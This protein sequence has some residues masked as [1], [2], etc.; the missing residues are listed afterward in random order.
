MKNVAKI[1]FILLLIPLGSFAQKYVIVQTLLGKVP[2]SFQA[3]Y[4]IID[5]RNEDKQGKSVFLKTLANET[6]YDRHLKKIPNDNLRKKLGDLTGHETLALLEPALVLEIKFSGKRIKA[7]PKYLLLKDPDLTIISYGDAYKFLIELTDENLNKYLKL[8]VKAKGFTNVTMKEILNKMLF[9]FQV[10]GYIEKDSVTITNYP[11]YEYYDENGKLKPY[12]NEAEKNLVKKLS[13]LQEKI[14]ARIDTLWKPQNPEKTFVARVYTY[15]SKFAAKC[16]TMNNFVERN[17]K[18]KK[19][20]SQIMELLKEQKIPI[21]HFSEFEKSMSYDQLTKKICD[22]SPS[23]DI[24]ETGC[25]K[26]TPDY[27]LTKSEIK[28]HI[29]KLET[30]FETSYYPIYAIVYLWKQTNGKIVLIP[31]QLIIIFSD[32]T[33]VIPDAAVFSIRIQD[34]NIPGFDYKEFISFVSDYKKIAFYPVKINEQN[35]KTCEEIKYYYKKLLMEN[36]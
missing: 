16:Y 11:L 13:E 28:N 7:I 32:R 18:M 8:V 23:D 31:K 20:H 35:M 21:F 34:L 27:K 12:T 19:F 5:N 26:H 25:G 2:K 33:G 9:S 29:Q 24:L 15:P 1:L 4:E 17:Q 10:R 14:V 3:N 30:M 36:K 22:Y 6:L